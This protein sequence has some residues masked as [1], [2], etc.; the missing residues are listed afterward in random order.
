M[1]PDPQAFAALRDASWYDRPNV[2]SLKLLHMAHVEIA[3]SGSRFMY[4]ACNGM[5]LDEA[6][7]WAAHEVPPG[8]RCGRPGCRVRWPAR[9]VSHNAA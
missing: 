3:D 9:E 4:A 1:Q 8:L 6:S 5:P 7:V 2:R